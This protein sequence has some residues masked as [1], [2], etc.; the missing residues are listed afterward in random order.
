MAHHQ[1]IA[2]DRAGA[3]GKAK[4]AGSA[5]H[6][7]STDQGSVGAFDEQGAVPSAAPRPSATR[8]NETVRCRVKEEH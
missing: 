6:G 4:D 5:E 3:D 8:D 7:L 1:S 2:I